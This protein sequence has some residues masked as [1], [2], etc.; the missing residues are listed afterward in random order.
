MKLK[1]K[2][3]MVFEPVATKL[4][5]YEWKTP[6]M[7]Y[8]VFKIANSVLEQKKFFMIEKSKLFQK[9]GEIRG[10]NIVIKK[11]N[12]DVFQKSI[13]EL[14]DMEVEIPEIEFTLDDVLD[15]GYIQSE[16]VGEKCEK[17]TPLDM[18]R[19]ETFLNVSKK[20]ETQDD[21]E[22]KTEIIGQFPAE[23]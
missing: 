12:E 5:N 1:I 14:L 23:E 10:E 13:D 8:N 9:Y 19:I 11:G 6:Q 3:V 21:C 7:S 22:S 17:L 18:Y 16:D 20:E 4:L 15:V 2:D